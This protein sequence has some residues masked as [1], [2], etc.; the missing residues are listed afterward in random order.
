MTLSGISVG[1]HLDIGH[2]G[3]PYLANHFVISEKKKV[4][5]F[6]SSSNHTFKSS[7]FGTG[8]SFAT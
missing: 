4:N 3:G 1:T 7:E 6:C 5:L 2:S 8:S